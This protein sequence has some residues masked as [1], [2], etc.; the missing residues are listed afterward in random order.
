MVPPCPPRPALAAARLCPRQSASA[1]LR[2]STRS[3]R[4]DARAGFGASF[5]AC[6]LAHL[7][8]CVAPFVAVPPTAHSSLASSY[9][10]LRAWPPHST[11]CAHRDFNGGR[12]GARP[13]ALR[14]VF[15]FCFSPSFLT[16]ILASPAAHPTC[17]LDQLRRPRDL[18][19]L[20]FVVSFLIVRL[21]AS[22]L[23]P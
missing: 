5:D 2:G 7:A 12:A 20:R 15:F 11:C 3:A 6:L 10:R 17:G 16:L 8:P 9:C 4:D 13:S 19:T 21:R 23:L 22:S 1:P 14:Y 18:P